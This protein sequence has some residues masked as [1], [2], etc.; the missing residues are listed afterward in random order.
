MGR[1]LAARNRLI[2]FT[3]YTYP[4]YTAAPHHWLI[5]AKLEAVERG[6]IKRLILEMPPRH[7]KSELASKRFPA[8][9]LGRNPENQII[10]ASYNSELARDFG[11]D[12]RNIVAGPEYGR[13]FDARLAADSAAAD[14]WHTSQGGSYVAAGVG[15]AVTGR[16]ANVFLID[17]PVKDRQDADSE[18]IRK[19]TIDWY[20]S[21]AYTRLMPGGSIIVIQTRWHEEDL[22]GWLLA[23]QDKG[24]DQ[25]DV[26]SLPAIDHAGQALWPDWYPIERLEQIRSVLPVRDWSALYQQRPAPEEGNYFKAEWLTEYTDDELEDDVGPIPLRVVGAS[27]YAVTADGG[28]YTV[29]IVVGIDP[30]GRMYVLD[31]Y[32]EQAST[33][34]WVEAFCQ[35]VLKW[36]PLFWGEESG[37]ILS[38]VG[39]YLTRRQQELSAYVA[40]ERFASKADKAVRAR[41]I[42]GR[43]QMRGLA[44]PKHAPWAADFRHELLTFPA[45]KNDDQ[46]DALGLVGQLLDHVTFPSW[47][48][49]E[50]PVKWGIQNINVRGRQSGVTFNDL[51]AKN[52]AALSE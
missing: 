29:H 25:W 35:I 49:E 43:M 16:G 11:R 42:Q 7:G 45:G 23:E 9:Y 32:R 33:N 30:T 41:S 51:L 10:A 28:D 14:R 39:P 2:P 20:T 38:S 47:P 34:D 22:A 13:L 3:E 1:I 6:E 5:A 18:L 31:L 15:T 37:Q 4:N 24:G 12:V 26:L 21:V 27:D 52:K 36:K 50:V 44:I 40:R 17:D 46:V 19:R 48:E 8:W